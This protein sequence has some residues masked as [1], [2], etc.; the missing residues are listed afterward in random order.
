MS[1]EVE[2]QTAAELEK[3]IATTQ[4]EAVK[5]APA[6]TEASKEE[7]KPE[8]KLE[9]HVYTAGDGTIYKAASSEELF[10][11][12]TDALN[13]TKTA[14]KDREHAIHDLKTKVPKEEKPAMPAY[15]HKRYL[16]LLEADSRAAYEYQKEHDPEIQEA[17]IARR[18]NEATQKVRD[19]VVRFYRDVPDYA[20]VETKELN[21]LMKHRLEE[22]ERA[23]TAE[24]LGMTY[25]ELRDE[26][27]IP[28]SADGGPVTKKTPPPGSP[29]GSGQTSDGE[30]DF[31]AMSSKELI[32]YMKK[33]KVPGA[34]YLH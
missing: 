31:D 7:Q 30:P 29:E 15:D 23:Y 25:Y 1:K 34:E 13:N 17:R 16:E 12:V 14:L 27:K 5:E 18:Q 9:E 8:T 10:R 20:K 26:G 19:E 3:T 22:K 2:E 21:D 6:A 11:K 24:S 28:K 4:A 32:A 33:Q